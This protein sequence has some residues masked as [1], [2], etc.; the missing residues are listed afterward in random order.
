MLAAI[1]VAHDG[2]HIP[3]TP[4]SFE[5]GSTFVDTQSSEHPIE[6]IADLSPREREVFLLVARCLSN[7][8]IA[9]TAFLSEATVKSHV[10]S[11]LH[12]LDLRSRVQVV[13]FA[14]EHNIIG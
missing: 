7:S 2:D 1:R 14:Y 13:E 4:D 6:T 11:I 5:L 10:R 9:E 8:Q 3:H 12:K